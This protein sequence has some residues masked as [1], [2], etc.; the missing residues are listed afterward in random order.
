M[1]LPVV[2]ATGKRYPN[3]KIIFHGG[4]PT[5]AGYDYLRQTVDLLGHRIYILQSNLFLLD[6]KIIQF[7]KEFC[8]NNIGTSF[9]VSRLSF[10]RQWLANISRLSDSN[11]L[12]TVVVTIT[13]ELRVADFAHYLRHFEKVGV[14]KFRLQFV[15]PIKTRPVAPDK[16]FEFFKEFYDHP[17][18]ETSTRVFSALCSQDL[19]AINGGN[20]A[21]SLRTVDPDGTVYVCPDLAG[22]KLLPIGNISDDSNESLSQ[23]CALFN[24]REINSVLN[25]CQEH[26]RICR[27]GCFAAAY[28]SSGSHV[29][30]DPYCEIYK[31]IFALCQAKADRHNNPDTLQ[32][33]FAGKVFR[34]EQ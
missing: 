9:D 14:H 31:K 2:E 1:S 7:V 13:D 21:R 4:E 23:T 6:N 32:A 29:S 27:G 20:C 26:W 5:I 18:N 12:V 34:T 10:Y 17:L 11:V 19:T 28:F 33:A 16:Y 8:S 15:T 25:C 30:R 3:A 22:Q 24:E